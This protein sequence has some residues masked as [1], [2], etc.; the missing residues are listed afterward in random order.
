[1]SQPLLV[2]A[3]GGTGG[4]MFPAQ[5]LA[6]VMLDRGWRVDLS[7]DARGARYADNFPPAVRRRVVAAGTTQRVGI[8]PKIQAPFQIAGGVAAAL[9]QF[10]KDRPACV[11]GFGGY[12][13]FPALAAA[14]MM[15]LPRL[16]HEQNGVLGRVNEIFA[17][18]VDALACGTWPTELPEGV[19]GIHTGNPLRAS[20]LERAAYQYTPPGDWPMDVLVIGGSQGASILSDVVP[21][22]L[23]TLPDDLRHRLTVA[24]H[25]READHAA[26]VQAYANADIRADVQPFFHD[27]ADRMMRAQLIISRSG[28]SSVADIAAIGRPSILVPLKIAKRGE[29]EA[30]AKGLVEQGAAIMLREDEF[31]PDTLASVVQDVLTT[32]DLAE[33]MAM[34]ALSLGIPD[35]A[36]KLADLVARVA[37]R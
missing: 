1:M 11:A 34:S 23:A 24:H 16:I 10:R 19:S 5:A 35:A 9:W 18:R 36:E 32:P 20:V 4:H 28:A 2:I 22:G 6:E 17:T 8:A 15:K 7:T 13:A 14:W 37:A 12:P 3:A 33:R 26:V 21:A 27:V 29:Q 31:D 30:N 25:A